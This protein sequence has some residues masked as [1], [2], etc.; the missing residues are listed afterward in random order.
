MPT[1]LTE[2]GYRLFFYADEGFEPAHVHVECQGAVS[3]FW[4]NPV[5]FAGTMGMKAPQIKRAAA[6]VEKHEQLVL[7]K[8]NEFFSK[9]V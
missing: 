6:L 2:G 8:W 7:E 1:I 5:Q 4:I 3:K 9:K